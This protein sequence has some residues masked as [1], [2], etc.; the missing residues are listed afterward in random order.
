MRECNTVAHEI[1]KED[2]NLSE[3]S[4]WV[5]EVPEVAAVAVT[6]DQWWVDPPD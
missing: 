3:N 2:F 4:F 1:A 6:V 5:E